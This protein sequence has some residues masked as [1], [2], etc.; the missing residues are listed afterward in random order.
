MRRRAFTL[1]EVVLVVALLGLMAGAT[2]WSLAASAQ[3]GS[4]EHAFGQLAGLDRAARLT[5]ERLG[6]PV[7]L[8]FDLDKQRVRRFVVSERDRHAASHTLT[9]PRG[10]KIDRVV[11]AG[12]DGRGGADADTFDVAFS[13][14]G[15]SVSY[16]LKLVAD[17][18]R[19][20]QWMV[21]GGLTGQVTMGFDED[22]VDNLF[23][24]LAAG[25]PDAD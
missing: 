17:D 14:G 7:V 19:T 10:V 18:P 8:R 20:A 13:T 22:E 23:A 25:R 1:M 15:R 9:M 21:V 2:T 4:R 12:S 6:E 16:A 11:T 3:R 5:A 24:T